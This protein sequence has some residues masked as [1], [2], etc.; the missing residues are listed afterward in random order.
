MLFLIGE[1]ESKDTVQLG[2]RQITSYLP[3]VEI[4]PY[5]NLSGFV[6]ILI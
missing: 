2:F 4:Y 5:A 3:E 1:G 6:D